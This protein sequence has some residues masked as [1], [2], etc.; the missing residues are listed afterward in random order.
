MRAVRVVPRHVRAEVRRDRVVA[1]AVDDPGARPARDVV[2]FVDDGADEVRLP[3]EVAVARPVA[4]R[5]AGEVDPVLRVGADGGAHDARLR[6]EPVER[7]DVVRVRDQDGQIVERVVLRREI[8][9]DRLE[10]VLAAS[11]DGPA[12]AGLRG[13]R[14]EVLRDEPP[15][16]AG[17]A[18]QDDVEAALFER[19]R[20]GR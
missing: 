12:N 6:D 11:G 1:R 15:G 19:H 5:G 3:R 10:L 17:G 4:R 7:G 16:E 8:A 13:V 18:E 20:S 14:R 9:T 2:A